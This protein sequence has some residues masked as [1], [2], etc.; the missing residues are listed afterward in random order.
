M[1]HIRK[2]WVQ[3]AAGARQL[4]LALGVML[5]KNTIRKRGIAFTL[6]VAGGVCI[7][8]ASAIHRN[9]LLTVAPVVAGLLGC[10]AALWVTSKNRGDIVKDQPKLLT[11]APRDQVT[12]RTVYNTKE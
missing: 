6:A 4:E 11:Q 10:S 2:R 9:L 5:S 7:I 8:T 1:R 3:P 12:Q